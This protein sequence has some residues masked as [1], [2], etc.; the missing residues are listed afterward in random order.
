M[1]KAGIDTSLE[2]SVGLVKKWGGGSWDL[3]ARE[4]YSLSLENADSGE[5]ESSRAQESSKGRAVGSGCL[6]SRSQ[7]ERLKRRRG[8]GGGVVCVVGG[9]LG[10]SGGQKRR[11]M[12]FDGLR[13]LAE[14]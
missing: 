2:V 1:E 3:G 11:E 13:F 8:M 10:Q 12:P 6:R 9:D 14:E 7:W 5:R 4:S